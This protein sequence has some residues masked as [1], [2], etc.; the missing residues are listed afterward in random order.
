[1]ARRLVILAS[2]DVG[3]ANSH[4]LTVAVAAF[5]ACEKVGMPE[6]EY[7]L[8]HAV[9]YLATSPKSNSVTRAMH[10]VK[11]ALREQPVQAVPMWLRD[12][13]TKTNKAMGHGDGYLYSHDYPH[14]IS[15]QEY[16]LEPRVFYQPVLAG[17]EVATAQRM[18]QLKKIKA[19]IQAEQGA[20]NS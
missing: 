8:A 19:Q 4:A 2:E 18:D 10:Q 16:M 13:H 14:G 1:M 6:C 12:A 15:G 9:V 20:G 7:A 5:D 11:Q 17:A 3:L